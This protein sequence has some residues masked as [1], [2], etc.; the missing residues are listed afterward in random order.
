MRSVEKISKTDI[1]YE[2]IKRDILMGEYRPNTIIKQS[3]IASQLN[4]S[5]IPVREALNRLASEGFVLHIP[6]TGIIVS[7]LSKDYLRMVYETRAVLEGF[8]VQKAVLKISRDE[9]QELRTILDKMKTAKENNDIEIYQKLNEDFHFFIYSRSGNNILVDHIKTLWKRFPR[10]SFS[11]IPLRLEKSYND[12]LQIFM[13]IE[14]Q[15]SM[16]CETLIVNHIK[17]AEN[18]IES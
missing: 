10:N 1:A 5:I 17:G 3:E 11:A 14:K 6:Y 4:I 15:D 8:A 2:K 18:D 9:I 12:H 13:A 7:E 16:W